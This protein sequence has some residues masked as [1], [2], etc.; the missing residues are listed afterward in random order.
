M[1]D[2]NV[3]FKYM[4]LNDFKSAGFSLSKEVQVIPVFHMKNNGDIFAVLIMNSNLCVK[5]FGDRYSNNK[6]LE[7]Y[8]VDSIRTNSLNTLPINESY[9]KKNSHVAFSTCYDVNLGKIILNVNYSPIIFVDVFVDNVQVLNGIIKSFRETFSK[10][11]TGVLESESDSV[12]MVYFSAEELFYLSRFTTYKIETS[13]EIIDVNIEEQGFPAKDDIS[14]IYEVDN[15]KGEI[16]VT[17]KYDSFANC[18]PEIE[19][20]TK[21]DITMGLAIC[22][23]SNAELPFMMR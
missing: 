17:D 21:R 11:R 15:S 2:V 6:T 18:S 7:S 13:G 22:A 14:I 5:S 9:V 20:Y 4:P 23:Y 12:A 16:P 8:V 19:F 10:I 3:E 1:S